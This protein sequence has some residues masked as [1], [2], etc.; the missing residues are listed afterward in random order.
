MHIVHLETGRHLFGGARQALDLVSGLQALGVRSTLV[1]PPD[2]E[3]AAAA[4]GLGVAVR[5]LAMSGD[6]DLRF[7][8]RL[9]RLLMELRPDLLHVHSR[10]GADTWGGLAA[11]KV[12]IPA[13]LTRRVDNPEGRLSTWKYRYY[14]CVIAISEAVRQE[15]RRARVPEERITMIRSA[16][17]PASCRPTWSRQRLIAEL[18]LGD[19]SLLVACVAQ[20]IARKGHRVLLDAW[21]TVVRAVPASRLL[22]FGGGPLERELRRRLQATP[23]AG[24]VL[25]AGFRA[26]LRAFLGCMDLL[27]HPAQREGLGL[28][29]LE[30][31]AAGL[32]VVAFRCGGLP[33]IVRDRENGLL[34][35]PGDTRRL[36][37]AI[38]MLLQDAPWRRALGE[39][40]RAR[41]AAV[42]LPQLVGAH[43]TLYR[44]LLKTG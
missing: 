33:E 42:G 11:R 9:Q 35:E 30:A 5:P 4:A 18:G 16:V 29:V 38:S 14:V 36:A 17:D 8:G 34:V 26:E 41:A 32:P 3:I 2:S 24:S 1:C 13:V 31:Q 28:A 40:A 25:I 23:L 44:H 7:I 22:L 20:M 27:V 6:L 37:T 21:P 19:D 10:R 43:L 12:G 39:A 15:L